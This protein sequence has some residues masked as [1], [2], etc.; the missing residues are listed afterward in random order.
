[1]GMFA[2]CVALLCT[3]ALSAFQEGDAVFW[4]YG[5]TTREGTVLKTAD[6]DRLLTILRRDGGEC[7][8]NETR[9]AHSKITLD[10][11]ARGFAPAELD[12][13]RQDE[14]AWAQAGRRLAACSCGN[15][16][17]CRLSLDSL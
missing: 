1:M 13:N 6:D 8:V 10:Q 4:K 11:N 17:T 9:C 3:T 16:V 15:C 2:I 7:M 12:T 14:A 5:D